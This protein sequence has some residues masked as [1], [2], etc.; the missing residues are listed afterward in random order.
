[1]HFWDQESIA[2]IENKS[3]IHLR[4]F[5]LV[6]K[7]FGTPIER[8]ITNQYLC[9]MKKLLFIF[10]IIFLLG[11]CNSVKRNQKLLSKANY[12]QAIEFGVKKLQK[13]HSSKKRDGHIAII[14]Q[15]FQK[16]VAKANRRISFLKKQGNASGAKEIYYT[17]QNIEY[18]QDKIRPLLPI[19]NVTLG[20]NAEFK[21]NDYGSKILDA[22]KAYVEY[23]YDEASLYMQ[24]QTRKDYRTAY[25]I[26][27]ELDDLQPNY[28]DL[29][30]KKE[31]ARFY[32]TDFILV[33]LKN[34]TNQI[35]PV[36]LQQELLSINTYGLDKFW[37]QYH[38][39]QETA[40]DYAY[41]I[42][43]NFR[44]ITIA[45]EKLNALQQRRSKRIKD[46]WEYQ[47]D[48]NGNVAKDS[49]GNDIKK[50]AYVTVSAKVIVTTQLKSAAVGADVVYTNLNANSEIN[51]LPI[52]SV[53]VFENVF[54]RYTGDK[55]AL[56]LKDKRF[57]QNRFIDFPTN[58]QMVY[59]TG[60]DL[61]L[62]LKEIIKNN[63]L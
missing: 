10:G 63:T 8:F 3:I 13:N 53:F 29:T 45:P 35:I 11:A 61:K 38:T 59:D 49:L 58:E 37:T 12:E 60:E 18:I 54:A 16:F 27:C 5:F 7:K 43:L 40:I 2:L 62:K 33:D 25:Y 14:E 56:T 26:Y 36:S 55:R 51:R 1:M 20:R 46:G 6:N 9:T 41:G 22:K 42:T 44:E 47:Y 31:N 30:L 19:Y 17:Y 23:L 15:A 4:K 52:Y 34:S 48:S 32:G 57:L 39:Q 24:Y 50:D 21:L 28:K